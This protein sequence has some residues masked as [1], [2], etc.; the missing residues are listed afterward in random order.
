[1]SESDTRDET[2]PKHDSQL[3]TV[4]IWA[5]VSDQGMVTWRGKVQQVPNGAWRYFHDWA[6]LTDFLQNQ[7]AARG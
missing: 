2:R 1:M 3:F 4:R 6:A 7:V 5:E